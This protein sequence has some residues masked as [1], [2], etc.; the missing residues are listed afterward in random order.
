[1]ATLSHGRGWLRDNAAVSIA[2]IDREIGHAMQITEA[3]RTWDQQNAHY[4]RYLRYLNGGPWAPIALRPGTSLHESGLAVD[5]DEGRRILDVMTRH[6]W[7]RT[8]YRDGVLVEPWHFEYQEWLDNHRHD[9]APAAAKPPA[10]ILEPE[11]EDYPDM[12]IA[13]CK[14]IWFLVVDKEAVRL[15]KDSDARASGIPVLNFPDDWA[16]ARLKNVVKGIDV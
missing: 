13:I 2:R 9:G 14:R 10:P 11:P 6:G 4:Q 3:G 12:F 1:M 15:H 8:V 5:T 16:V 7:R